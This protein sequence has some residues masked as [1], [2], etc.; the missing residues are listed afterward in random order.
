MRRRAIVRGLN[1]H[2]RVCDIS[3]EFAMPSNEADRVKY[4]VVQKRYFKRYVGRGVCFDPPA[5]AVAQTARAQ[6]H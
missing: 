2:R 1:R 3:E 6:A 4:E 5:S